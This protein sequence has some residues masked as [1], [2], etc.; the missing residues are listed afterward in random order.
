LVKNKTRF[1]DDNNMSNNVMDNNRFQRIC[2]TI[3]MIQYSALSIKYIN[4]YINNIIHV[5]P[6]M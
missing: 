4:I 2:L 6:P 1:V 3:D 5:K